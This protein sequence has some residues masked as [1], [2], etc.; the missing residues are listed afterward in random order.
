MSTEKDINIK[1]I[2]IIFTVCPKNEEKLL[3][4]E[5]SLLNNCKPIVSIET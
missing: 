4:D 3:K 2:P 5:E 1:F